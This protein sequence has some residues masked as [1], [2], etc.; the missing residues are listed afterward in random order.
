M[1]M[2]TSTHTCKNVSAAH[3]SRAR[4]ACTAGLALA[5]CVG[6]AA[7]LPSIAWADDAPESMG[8]AEPQEGGQPGDMGEAPGG[9]GGGAGG[10][11][12]DTQNFDYSGTY[13]GTVSADGTETSVDGESVDASESQVNAVLAQ[14]GGI[15]SLVNAS[16]TKSG[17]AS[18]DDACNFYGVNSIVLAVGED[19]LIRVS[20]STLT[21]TSEGSNALFATDGATIW[22]NNVSI[23]TESDNSRGLDATYGGTVIANETTID[24]EGDHCAGA[25]N[26]RGGGYVSVTNST[27]ETAGSGSPILYS[28]GCVEADNVTGTA[29]GSQ[30]AG[31][32][33]LNTIRIANSTLV[34]TITQATASDPIAN[35]V[36]IYQSTSGDADTSTGER[37]L[38][39][40]RDSSL[41]SSIESG[42]M[43]Y[44]TNTSADILLVRSDLSFDADAANLITVEGNDSN[45][46]GTAGENGAD[47]TLTAR[48]Q[49]LEGNI[50]V[51][52]ISSLTLYLLDGSTYTGAMYITENGVAST[53]DEPL[54]ITIES[55]STWV[56]TAD[57]TVSNLSVE[58]GGSVVD[59]DGNTVTIV[60]DGETVVSGESDLT[61]TVEGSY[62]T[63]IDASDALELSEGSI[64][65]TDFD[66]YYETST[67]FGT[68]GDAT[69]TTADTSTADESAED[70]EAASEAEGDDEEE[71]GFFSWLQDLWEW[72]VSLFS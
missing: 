64:D 34:S 19:S 44:L 27:I 22:A 53:V 3:P 29:T 31:M 32:E 8:S 46:W 72:L 42:S 6:S 2:L 7:V 43:F 9:S 23:Q 20:D 68:N 67:T 28:T 50:S 26:D 33:G 12:A 71:G 69:A 15:V 62:A 5:L 45:N 70:D 47:V 49:A 24:T 10:S 56:V 1:T 66:A 61:V 51:D 52:T 14:N 65:R 11:S 16:L 48:E 37:A 35:G 58:D 25:A 38:F 63:E 40:V 4:V 59:E 30:L 21:A 60:A 13:S 39:E 36:I 55:G 18:D 41:S 57:S 54:S 17:D